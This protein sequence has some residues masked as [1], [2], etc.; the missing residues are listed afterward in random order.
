L[1]EGGAGNDTAL[2]RGYFSDYVITYDGATQTVTL[3]DQYLGR[4]GTDSV[5]GVESFAFADGMKT[6]DD[7]LMG[8]PQP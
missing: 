8:V 4:D 3:A 1:I 2:L 5:Q 6:L 7:L